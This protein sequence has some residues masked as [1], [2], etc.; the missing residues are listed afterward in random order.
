M[1]SINDI[2]GD[3]LISKP[4]TDAYRDNKF[5]DKP[6]DVEDACKEESSSQEEEKELQEGIC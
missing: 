5:W 1:S 3:R 2:T 4:S 6:R